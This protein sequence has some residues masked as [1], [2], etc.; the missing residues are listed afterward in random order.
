MRIAISGTASQGKSTLLDDFLGEWKSYTTPET[1]YR[2]ALSTKDS[3][4]S[5]NT[6]EDTQWDVLNHMVDT[7][8]EYKKGDRVIFDRCPLD[9]IV[10]TLWANEKGTISKEFV[11]KCIPIVKES[12]RALDIIFFIP[13]TKAHKVPIIDD[14]TRETDPQYIRE[15]DNVFKALLQYYY[16]DTGPFFVHDDKPAIIEVF[17]DRLAR[18]EIIKLYLDTDGDPI[19]EQG[20]LDPGEI[21]MLEQQFGLDK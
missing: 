9:N 8:Q 18:L 3:G 10:Y 7:L 4:H 16:Q 21:S 17:G 14:G 5:K 15:I 20:I 1:T 2:D 13:L 12:L 11:D 6:T 19:G